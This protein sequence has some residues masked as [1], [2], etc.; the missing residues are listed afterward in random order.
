[1]EKYTHI[2]NLDRTKHPIITSDICHY[3]LCASLDILLQQLDLNT[4]LPKKRKRFSDLD[5]CKRW[6]TNSFYGKR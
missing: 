5:Y 3:I 6:K 4:P 2:Y 1:M